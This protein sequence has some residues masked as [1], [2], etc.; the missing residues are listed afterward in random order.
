MIEAKK[1]SSYAPLHIYEYAWNTSLDEP[2]VHPYMAI[3]TSIRE[4][5]VWTLTKQMEKKNNI[6]RKQNWYAGCFI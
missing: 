1:A 3:I 6:D 4:C 2:K 5:K